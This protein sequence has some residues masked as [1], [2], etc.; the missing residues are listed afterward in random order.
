LSSLVSPAVIFVFLDGLGLGPADDTNPLWLAPMPNLRRLLGGPLVA[1][2]KVD[3]PGLLFK[4][5][6]ALLGVQGVPQSATGQTALFTGVNAAQL[7]G[8][9]LGAYPTGP[10]IE[11]INQHNILKRA[12]ERG[13]RATF[14]NAYTPQY[15]QLVKERKRRHSATTLS[16]LAAGLPFRTLE[17]LKRGEA[18]Y[19]DITNFY[20]AEHLQA[21]MLIIE[22]E[23]AGQRLA[24]L[25]RN[26]DL[27]LYESFLPDAVGHRKDRET[28]MEILDMLDRFFAGLLEEVEPTVTVVMA[29][30]TVTWRNCRW[31]FTA[32][33]PC[34]SWPWDPERRSSVGPRLLPTWLGILC[35]Y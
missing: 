12:S 17:D 10:L 14:A 34:P 6:D 18:V 24:R 31:G 1:G 7:V 35:G 30:T 4:G 27:V 5:I 25:S 8:Q 15:F 9:H 28:A 11:V 32:Q 16:V 19:W 33:I 3:R 26:H 21:P 22:P 23:I 29:A 2:T 13:Y 20:L